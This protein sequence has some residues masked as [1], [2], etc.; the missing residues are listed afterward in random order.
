MQSKIIAKDT[1]IE[2]CEKTINHLREL[3]V[4]HAKIPG[5]DNLDMIARKYASQDNDKHFDYSYYI[6]CIQL[7]QGMQLQQR[8]NDYKKNFQKVKK[9]W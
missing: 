9:S 6:V 7:K 8:G 5:L 4:A 1:Q 2:Q 3:Y